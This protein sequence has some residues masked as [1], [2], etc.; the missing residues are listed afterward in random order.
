MQDGQPPRRQALGLD[1]L[2]LLEPQ[3]Q[4]LHRQSLGPARE[5]ITLQLVD[6]LAQPLVL[7]TLRREHRPKRDRIVGNRFGRVAHKA[8]SMTNYM[9]GDVN[10]RGPFGL[11]LSGHRSRS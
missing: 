11:T 5:A 1:L 7:G 3:Q 6:D 4:L 8:V 9:A 2:G 10:R